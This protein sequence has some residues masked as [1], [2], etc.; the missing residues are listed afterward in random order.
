MSQGS[1]FGKLAVLI[2]LSAGLVGCAGGLF[3]SSPPASSTAP[4]ALKST[5]PSAQD[6][7]L[8]V[9][10]SATLEPPAGTRF[11]SGQDSAD[12]SDDYTITSQ[13]VLQ[14]T[15]FQVPDLA[16]TVRVD[17]TGF[18]SLPLVGRVLVRGKTILQAQEDI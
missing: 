18:V 6:T 13:D 12:L 11:A 10:D 9:A 4:A 8:P 15:I 5:S 7:R 14:V 16:R 3:L 1:R 17:G 2:A